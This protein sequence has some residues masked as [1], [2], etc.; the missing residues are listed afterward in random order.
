MVEI[1]IDYMGDLRC[2]ATHGPSGNTLLTDAPLDN[3][4]RGETFS[5][6]DLV[7]TALGTCMLTVM[8]IVAQRHGL[9][10]TGATAT[11]AKEMVQAPLRR[12]GRLTVHIRVPAELAPADQE[13]L[14]NAARHCPVHESLR[15]EVEMPITFHFGA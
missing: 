13:R 3:H 1:R 11:V 8:G 10:L 9:D 12:I 2:R 15:P 6:T 5:S 14:R 7:A 4:G